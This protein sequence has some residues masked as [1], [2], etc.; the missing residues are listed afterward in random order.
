[1]ATSGNFTTTNQYIKYKI[2]VTETATSDQDNTSTINIKVKA[3]RTN[4]EYTG[5]TNYA[6]SCSCTVDGTSLPNS[7]WNFD[8]KPIKYQS[9]SDNGTVLYDRD[10]TINHESDGSKTINVAAKFEL[11]YTNGGI[12]WN[13]NYQGFNVTLTQLQGECQISISPLTVGLNSLSFTANST[14]EC[15]DWKYSLDSGATFTPFSSASGTSVN[16]TV[17]GL[18]PNTMYRLVVAATKTGTTKTFKSH[19]YRVK[20]TSDIV[21]KVIDSSITLFEQGSTDFSTNGIGSL[22]DYTKTIV[23]EEENGAFELSMDY[24]ISGARFK[25]IVHG[26]V[27][28][29]KP[30]QY[31]DPQGFDIYSISKPHN[32]IV[33]ICAAHVS[34]R[35]S[36]YTLPPFKIGSITQGFALLNDETKLDV[37]CG[38]T[39]L[40]DKTD[41]GAL[42]YKVPSNIRYVLGGSDESFLGKYGGQFEFNNFQVNL[43]TQ[44]GNDRGVTI[45]YGKNL[46]SLKQDENCNNM[47]TAVRPYWY[48]EVKEDSS[49]SNDGGLVV[50]DEK[51]VPVIENATYTR[52]LPLDLTSEFD[53]KPTQAKLRAKTQEYIEKNNLNTP[54]ISLDVSFVQ[55]SD[56]EEYKDIAVLERVQLCDEVTVEFP[57]LG[58]HAKAKVVKTTYNVGLQRYESI[59]LGTL[60]T[61]LSTTLAENDA[62]IKEKATRS[63][64][65]NTSN[66]I[67]EDYQAA[68]NAASNNIAGYNGGTIVLDPPDNPNRLLLMDTDRMD[69]AV[70]VWQWNINGLGFSDDGINGDYGDD[71]AITNDGHIN[72]NFITVGYLNGGIID[73]GTITADALSQEYRDSVQNSIDGSANTV[74]QEF[75]AANAELDSKITNTATEMND[76]VTLINTDISELRQD[77][78]SINFAFTNQTMGGVNLIQNSSGSNGVDGNWQTAGVSGGVVANHGSDAQKNTVS[79]SMFVLTSPS[80]DDVAILSQE[81]NVIIGHEYAFSLKIKQN[82]SAISEIVIDNGGTDIVVY[83]KTETTDWSEST[84]GFI[85]SSDNIKIQALT[86]GNNLWIADLM[87]TEGNAQSTWTPAPNEIYTENVRIDKKGINISNSESLTQTQID[88]EKFAII[89]QGEE[90]LRVNKDL[91]TLARTDIVGKLTVGKGQ[92]VPHFDSHGNSD[93]MDFV[94]LD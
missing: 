86:H 72:A 26:R 29:A 91:T 40:T 85:A 6:G 65:D 79:G 21:K 87:L 92:F 1:M 55:L 27:L 42:E 11:H 2:I 63:E 64:L 33:T 56:S 12:K 73:A 5:N 15:T 44:R 58:V 31:D 57:K 89:H 22:P 3:W 18:N 50:L 48:R 45:R 61:N 90:V 25:E 24:P 10:T 34:Y 68:A 78:N 67:A 84:I 66:A 71:V 76:N 81:V 46:T 36:G 77:I 41:S 47:F 94:L 59:E 62:S 38:F 75:R 53:E 88:H 14:E 70:K 69:T 17:D 37:P 32:G 49:K 7:T 54:E 39:F 52:I 51:F 82:T 80:A 13:S 20:T 74:R 16:K 60:K 4:S 93:G 9:N 8:D 83:S 28:V 19:V 35:L 23:L 30:N 43:W